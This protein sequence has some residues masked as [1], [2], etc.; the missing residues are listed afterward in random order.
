LTER[1]EARTITAALEVTLVS[2]SRDAP[3]SAELKSAFVEEMGQ[4]LAGFGWPHMAGRILAA[5]LVATPPEQSAAQL[6]ETLQASRGSISTM[7]R[8]LETPGLIQRVR[9]PGDRKVYYRNTPDGWF[10]AMRSEAGN[11]RAARELAERGEALMADEP[12]DARRGIED[13]L[14]FLRFWEREM[15]AVLDRWETYR[16]GRDP[17][18][19]GRR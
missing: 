3:P 17:A 5:L 18:E 16:Q 10:L 15:Q 8:M 19:A 4:Q 9:K 2:P 14:E 6:A 11:I 12:P 1:F 13:T 7:T